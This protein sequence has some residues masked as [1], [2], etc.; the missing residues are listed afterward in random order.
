MIPAELE[1]IRASIDNL[2]ATI[3]F[4]LS[5]RFKQT[6]KVGEI[7]AK[8]SLPPADPDREDQQIK[9]LRALAVQANLDP[10]FAERF[11]RFVIEEVI[12][13][14]RKTAAESAGSNGVTQ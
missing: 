13:H 11:L 9:R 10:V 14:H 4:I 3:I 12:Q 1:E 2:D 5:E 7:K 6:K 8:Y